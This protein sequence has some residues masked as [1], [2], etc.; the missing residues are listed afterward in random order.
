M[1]Y[2]ILALV[3][4]LCLLLCGCDGEEIPET[5]ATEAPR[6][7]VASVD[8]PELYDLPVKENLL[9]QNWLLSGQPDLIITDRLPEEIT[10]PVILVGSA[11]A[12]NELVYT[13]DYQ[14]DTLAPQQV[15]LLTQLPYQG[16]LNRDGVITYAILAPTGTDYKTAC[17]AA[18]GSHNLLNSQTCLDDQAVGRQAAIRILSSYGKDLDILLCGSE[19]LSLGASAAAKDVGRITNQDLIL[20]T[21]GA[22]IPRASGTVYADPN[23]MIDAILACVNAPADMQL[24]LIATTK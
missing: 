4:V 22:D 18:M 16:D 3:F 7:P 21:V 23:A 9:V 2:R 20:L 11:D 6:L 14:W 15:S 12:E 17:Q 10:M 5:T 24:P 19:A 1:K 8:L 13:I